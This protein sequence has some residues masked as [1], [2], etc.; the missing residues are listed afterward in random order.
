MELSTLSV[1]VN[2]DDKKSFET[3]LDK[4]KEKKKD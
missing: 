1:R 2:S 3:F 4:K